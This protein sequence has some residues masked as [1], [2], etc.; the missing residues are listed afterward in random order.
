ME[1]A[2]SDQ[3]TSRLTYVPHLVLPVSERDHIQGPLTAT[4][5]LVEYGDFECPYCGAAYP[6]VKQVKAAMGD[7]FAFVFRHFPLSN[8]HPHAWMA[9]EAAEAAGAQG[10]FWQMHDTLFEHQDTLDEPHLVANARGL[11]LDVARFATELHEGV[12]ARRVH[13]D[14]RSGI[15][16]GVNGTPSFFINGIRYDGRWDAEALLSALRG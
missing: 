4:Q 3:G 16:S 11:G 14:F 7:D 15:L 6:I 5:V 8:V 1:P 10:A 12:H 13:E 9:A 2:L